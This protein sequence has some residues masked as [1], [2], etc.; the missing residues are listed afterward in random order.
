[1]NLFKRVAVVVTLAVGLLPQAFAAEP[2]Q[3]ENLQGTWSGKRT[4]ENGA[5][6]TQT[7]EVAGD[8]LTYTL[9]NADNEVRLFAK[10]TIKADKLGPFL[11]MKLT[12]LQAGRSATDTQAVED[13]R[14][15]VYR[16]AEDTLILAS[17]FDKERENQKPTVESYKRTARPKA[18][19][20][21]KLT[22]KWKMLVR[23]GEDERDYDLAFAGTGEALTAVLTSA[24]SGEHKFKTVTF[25]DGKLA[26]ELVRD[27][28]GTEATLQYAG[29]FKD[30]ALTGTVTVKGF[31]EQFKGTW[32]AKR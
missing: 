10:G 31:E 2:S 12:D 7:I 16:L 21:D 9:A 3:L 30:D 8:K 22:G 1:M 14:T 28:Q 26:M 20:A 18:A 5:E 19:S 17:N 6:L 4:T 24:R 32:T 13:E 25:A 15:T 29:E 27:I 11:V 23:L